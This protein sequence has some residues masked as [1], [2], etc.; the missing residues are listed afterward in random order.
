MVLPRLLLRVI[1]P[2]GAYLD[3]PARRRRGPTYRGAAVFGPDVPGGS[4]QATAEE[5]DDLRR[6]ADEH[7]RARR[8][9]AVPVDRGDV[10]RAVADLLSTGR[11]VLGQG[12]RTVHARILRFWRGSSVLEVSNQAGTSRSSSR[13]RIRRNPGPEDERVLADYL[14]FFVQHLDP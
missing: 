2:A 4:R 8:L 11:A 5:I 12:P 13:T 7:E 3:G 1:D 9:T 10:E 14:V 6:A